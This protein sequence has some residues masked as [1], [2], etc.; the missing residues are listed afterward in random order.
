MIA[1]VRDE[2]LEEAQVVAVLGVPEHADG[3]RVAAGFE[4]L[5]RAVVGA[6]HHLEAFAQPAVALV[7]VRGDL[8]RVA[9]DR[10]QARA[11]VDRDG[12]LREHAGR[13]LVAFVSD[14]VGHVLLEIAAQRHIQHLRAAADGEDGHVAFESRGEQGDLGAVALGTDV[15]GLRVR[16]GVVQRRVQVRPAREDEPV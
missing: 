3:E 14:E 6:R 13:L 16:L 12:V 4:R 9:D 1:G 10:V 15:V 8:D 7:V 5:D 2:L 11:F